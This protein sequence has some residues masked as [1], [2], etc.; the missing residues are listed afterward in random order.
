MNKTDNEERKRK[1]IFC[2]KGFSIALLGLILIILLFGLLLPKEPDIIKGVT[3]DLKYPGISH[4]SQI[5]LEIF[6]KDFKMM[7]KAGINTIRLYGIPPEFVLDLAD[8]YRIKVIETIV[9]P[10]DWTDFTSPYQLQALKREIVR[11]INRD[12]NRECIYA[13]SIWNDAPW[14]Y[15]TGKGD[16]IRAYGK[17][18]VEKFLKEL[19]ECTKKHDPLRPI[20]AATLTLNDEAKRLGADFLDILGYNIYLGITEW[21]DG[22]YNAETAK[23]M[24][25]ELVS[26]SEEY[27]K[28]VII[29]ETGYSTYWKREQQRYVI[30]DQIEKVN[31]KIAG[32]ILFQWADDWSKAGYNKSQADDV[33]EH[34]GMVEGDRKPKGGYYALERLFNNSAYHTVMYTI[35]DYLRGGYFAGKKR[36][37]KNRW[38]ENVIVDKE[39]EKLE[40]EMS[41]KESTGEIPDILDRLS[42]KFF[43][44]RGFD[45]FTAFLKEYSITHKDSKYKA[46]IDYY[47]AL[48]GWNK[49]E[50]LAKNKMWLLYY[51]EKTRSLKN[52]IDQLESAEISSGGQRGYLDILYLKWLIQNDL[53]EGRENIALKRLEEEVKRY[54]V[55]YKDIVP[56]ITYS[57]LILNEGERQVSERLLREYAIN[58]SNF[59]PTDE[60]M[61]MLKEQAENALD[62]GDTDRAKILYDAYLE[63][64]IKTASAEDAASAILDLA[65]LYRRNGMFDDSV[66]LCKKLLSEFPNSD[67][68]D[69]ASYAIGAVLKEQKSY[70]K[71]VKAFR[72]FILAYPNSAL[73]KSTIKEVLSI[74]TVYGKGTRAEKTVSFLKEIIAL[75]PDSDFTVMARFELASSLESLASY[76]EAKREYEYI[77]KNYPKSE[78]A[79]YSKNNIEHLGER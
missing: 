34:W 25:D 36:A 2:I 16:V 13:W 47:I 71:A 42:A 78:Y 76:D 45:Q 12:I 57:K 19:Y 44:K 66:D 17:E 53:L 5:P 4:Y 35:A 18:R 7:K 28:P 14:T 72:D 29:T 24:V 70:S 15:G 67:L 54:A 33:E 60:A 49:L 43:E 55:T 46:L 74:F 9:F 65:S 10:G 41:L 69:D 21:R 51:A 61:V 52:I 32:I 40:N 56:L 22:N 3:Y 50:Y 79:A 26:L 68:A 38:K 23:K 48:S 31:K 39:I 64:L 37:L 73:T 58:V 1:K 63:I 30:S 8:K 62:S 59:M 77:I 27:K 6:E 20:T 11:N 75:Y